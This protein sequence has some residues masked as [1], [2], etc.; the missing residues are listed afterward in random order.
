MR[1]AAGA[2]ALIAFAFTASGAKDAPGAPPS[3]SFGADIQPLLNDHCLA[4][5]QTGSSEQGLN[6]EE[7]KAWQDLVGVRSKESKLALV[8]S[9]QPDQSY[10]LHKVQGSQQS[11]GGGGVQM[12]IG[13]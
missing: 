6:L 12:P 11:A 9:G 10:L 13:D 2:V 5:H 4:C 1:V 8:A 7:G 3:I